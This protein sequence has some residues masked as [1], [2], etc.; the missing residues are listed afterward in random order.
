[1]LSMVS[2][3]LPTNLENYSSLGFIYGDYYEKNSLVF[4]DYIFDDWSVWM[5]VE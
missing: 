1:M 3:E 4:T 2:D 5:Y